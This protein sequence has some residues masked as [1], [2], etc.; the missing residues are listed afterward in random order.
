MELKNQPSLSKT[1]NKVGA[2]LLLN[3]ILFVPV[4]KLVKRFLN[5]E[6]IHLGNFASF[7]SLLILSLILL[8]VDF[9]I[10]FTRK[11]ERYHLGIKDYILLTVLFLSFNRLFWLSYIY[12]TGFYKLKITM[13]T[14]SGFSANIMLATISAALAVVCEEVIYRGIILENLRRYGDLFAIII[15]GII[16]GLDH[17][18]LVIIKS[19]AGIIFGI[20]YVLGGNVRWVILVHFI[21]NLING[22]VKPSLLLR[23]PE[24]S[25]VNVDLTILVACI[26]IF[27]ISLILSF[28]DKNLRPLFEK[29]NWKKIKNQFKQDKEK[30]KEFFKAPAIAFYLVLQFMAALELCFDFLY[31]TLGGR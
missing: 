17:N 19:M 2:I 15:S 13:T 18:I 1:A 9:N 4:L 5:F 28:K 7:L 26:I 23:F 31:A 25:P 27:I 10:M 14:E 3:Y 24:I 8:K 21:A 20:V 29:W 6:F 30:Y 22:I 11:V 16:F 12:G